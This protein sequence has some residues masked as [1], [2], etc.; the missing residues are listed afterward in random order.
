LRER[1]RESELIGVDT[2]MM[3]RGEGKE[4]PNYG[5]EKHVL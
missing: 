2:L 1:E 5:N 4:G 3:G